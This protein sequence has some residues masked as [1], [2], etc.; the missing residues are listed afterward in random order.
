MNNPEEVIRKLLAMAEGGTEHEALVAAQKASLLALK[1]NIDILALQ[2]KPEDYKDDHLHQD[3]KVDRWVSNILHGVANLNA[4]K[5]YRSHNPDTDDW[6]YRLVG[7]QHNI[8]ITRSITQYLVNE[9]RRLN[10]SHVKDKPHLNTAPA[11]ADYRKAF[12]LAASQR[13]YSRLTDLLSELQNHPEVAP[14]A[15]QTNALVV[16][17]YFKTEAQACEDFISKNIGALTFTK[18]RPLR[19]NSTEGYRDGQNAANKISL[20]TQLES[21]H[22]TTRLSTK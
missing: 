12:R 7:K 16:A 11:R 18:E 19:I 22:G 9:V 13:L 6:S 20:N 10:T 17:D 4:V 21:S 1:Y 3:I 15:L 14:L 5:H 2:T 8:N